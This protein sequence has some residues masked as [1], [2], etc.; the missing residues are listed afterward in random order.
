MQNTIQ[1]I[2]NPTQEQC[3][4]AVR[5]G[6]SK[7][8]IY[9]KPELQNEEMCLRAVMSD[10]IM[11]DRVRPDLQTTEVCRKAA[12]QLCRQLKQC[13]YD[14]K[15]NYDGKFLKRILVACR[16]YDR[17]NIQISIESGKDKNNKNTYSLKKV[18]KISDVYVYQS[19]CDLLLYGSTI[20]F[21]VPEID[22]DIVHFVYYDDDRDYN[23]VNEICS[24]TLFNPPPD[25]ESYGVYINICDEFKSAISLFITRE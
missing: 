9:V 7:E 2:E 12:K 15:N 25:Q 20:Q 19:E 8:F 5:A 24:F 1:N 10:G 21:T 3:L 14:E 23:H 17:D 22:H 16:S 18:G 13:C 11:F 4:R 6:G